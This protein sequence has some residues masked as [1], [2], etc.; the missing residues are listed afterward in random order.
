MRTGPLVI[1]SMIAATFAQVTREQPKPV[2]AGAPIAH[3]ARGV[4]SGPGT[5][6]P[7]TGRV[8]SRTTANRDLPGLRTVRHR[9]SNPAIIG[10]PASLNA[11]RNTALNGT[12]LKEHR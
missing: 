8:K 11:S 1:V 3:A 5:S 7:L 2:P 6:G 10:G 4:A 12:R 9:G